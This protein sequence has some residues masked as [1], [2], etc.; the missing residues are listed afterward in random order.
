MWLV[1]RTYTTN[2]VLEEKCKVLSRRF[3][4]LEER[5][6]RLDRSGGA[7]PLPS[8]ST[9]TSHSGTIDEAMISRI[10]EQRLESHSREMQ[11]ARADLKKDLLDCFERVGA[12]TARDIDT[13]KKGHKSSVSDIAQTSTVTDNLSDSVAEVR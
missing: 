11:M 8:S 13:L 9:H 2:T 10:V 5:V 6:S 4:L 12:V 7:T 1:P 3:D